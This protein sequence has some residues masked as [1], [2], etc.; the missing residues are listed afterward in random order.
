ME[1]KIIHQ[2]ALNFYQKSILESVNYPLDK[3]FFEC[4]FEKENQKDFI[5]IFIYNLNNL[6]NTYNIRF[7]LLTIDYL[8]LFDKLDWIYIYESLENESAINTLSS[9]YESYLLLIPN[10]N[11]LNNKINCSYIYSIDEDGFI[12]NDMKKKIDNLK[13]R[14]IALGIANHKYG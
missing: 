10:K 5:E 7:I 11:I 2:F 3:D 14:I 6:P 1:N 8:V 9:F 12:N 13:N 4:N